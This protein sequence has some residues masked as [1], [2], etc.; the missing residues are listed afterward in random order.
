MAKVGFFVKAITNLKLGFQLQDIKRQV[1]RKEFMI[2][3]G[4]EM[5]RL[6]LGRTRTGYGVSNDKIDNP[7]KVRLASLSDTYIEFRRKRIGF[8]P[9]RFFSPSFSNLSLTGQMLDSLD[10]E[11]REGFVK[12]YVRDNSRTGYGSGKTNKEVADHVRVK[13]PFMAIDKEQKL[14]IDRMIDRETRAVVR[15]S[16]RK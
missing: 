11:A 15:R 3:I 12:V 9:G 4:E 14:V 13:R 8:R 7:S 2:K 10:I 6:I 1:R 5:K 16:L